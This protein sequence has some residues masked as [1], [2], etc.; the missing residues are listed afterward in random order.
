VLLTRLG[1]LDEAQHEFEAT[2]QLEPA[3][4]D[5]REYLARALALKRG[6]P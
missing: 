4:A 3:Y 2:L 1:R 5:A 6:A